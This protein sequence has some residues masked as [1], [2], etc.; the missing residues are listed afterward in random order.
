MDKLEDIIKKRRLQRQGHVHRIE[1]GRTPKQTLTWN[2]AGKWK[3]GRPRMN[4]T[5]GQKGFGKHRHDL[6][7][8]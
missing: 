4:W 5:N 8:S 2:P 1:Q 3:S 7:G 6:G